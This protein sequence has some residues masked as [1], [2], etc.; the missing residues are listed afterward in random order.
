MDYENIIEKYPSTKSRT[1]L[2][3]DYEDEKEEDFGKEILNFDSLSL[4]PQIPV[5]LSW[6][7]GCLPLYQDYSCPHV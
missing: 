2:S 3:K 7:A 5:C 6:P 4:P 1:L